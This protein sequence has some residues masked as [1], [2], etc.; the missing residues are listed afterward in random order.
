MQ[1][2]LNLM[3][4]L[5]GVLVSTSNNHEPANT[6]QDDSWPESINTV[7]QAFYL[8]TYE[9]AIVLE[10]NKVRNNP[11]RYAADYLE[12]LKAAYN[13]KVLT[14]PGEA[15]LQTREG[16][17]ALEEAIQALKTAAPVPP[18]EPSRS[19]TSAAEL[20]VKDQ[21]S[22]GGTGHLTK[23]GW[24]PQVRVKRFGTYTSRLAENLVYGYT[25]AQYA[26]ISLL[27]DDGV[28]N[29]GHRANILDAGFTTVGVAADKHPTY[30]YFCTIEFT[31]GFT[32]TGR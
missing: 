20:L 14:F 21:K 30:N 25:N 7:E 29:R 10:L 19:L 11:A 23:S 26:I 9:K 15:P 28:A 5:F 12:P 4:I 6:P 31:D 18:L 22:Y 13:N 2:I 16:V 32:A 27:I 24:T 17:A 8:D 3:L 1:A